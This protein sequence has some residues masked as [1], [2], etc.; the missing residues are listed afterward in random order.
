MI[1]IQRVYDK[2]PD[3]D[4]LR[5]LVDRIWP[6]GIKK[7]DLK[8]DGWLKDIAPTQ[9]LRNWFKHDPAKWNE[10]KQR[11][12]AEL[13]ANP[14]AWRPLLTQAKT[15]NITLLYGARDKEHNNALVLMEFMKAK[16]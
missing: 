7:S 16:L 14:D 10:F 1:R 4:S 5:F 8:L 9:N 2:Q 11:Y 3:D 15:K 6:R 12:T 13:N